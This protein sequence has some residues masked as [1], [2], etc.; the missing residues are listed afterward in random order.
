M[1]STIKKM[2]VSAMFLAL[3][4]VLP[5]LTMQIPQFGAMLSPMHFPVLLCGYFCG[6]PWGL[7]VGCIAP[8]L[9][10]LVLGMPIMFPMAICMA[11]ELATYGAVAG[12]LYQVLPTKKSNVFVSLVVAMIVGRMVWGMAMFACMGFDAARFG[13]TAFISGS[14]L[15]AIP[16]IILQVIIVPGLV[17]TLDKNP[18]K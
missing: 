15:N 13:F 17:M 7:L 3:A 16:G 11:F 6:W 12:Y 5:F 18:V 10:S 14:I 9:R 4:F 1:N 8:L 2:T